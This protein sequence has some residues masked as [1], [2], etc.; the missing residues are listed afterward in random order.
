M[1]NLIPTQK[2]LRLG[3]AALMLFAL[4][5]C[6]GRNAATAPPALRTQPHTKYVLYIGLNDGDTGEQRISTAEAKRIMREIGGKYADG[7]TLYE[8][9]GYWRAAPGAAMQQ[10]H[11]LVCVFIDAPPQAVKNIMDEAIRTFN[12]RSIL[13]EVTKAHS[14]LYNGTGKEADSDD[15]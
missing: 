4:A 1:L 14:L 2:T 3:L 5:A 6:A 15:G 9:A 13:L 10:E 12:Q 11:T 7:F 8:A